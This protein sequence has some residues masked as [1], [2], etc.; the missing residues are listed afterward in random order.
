[1]YVSG[2]VTLSL[3]SV[4][5][6]AQTHSNSRVLQAR[7]A[8]SVLS[9]PNVTTVSSS[10]GLYVQAL[11]GGQVD[12]SG[13]NQ[14]VQGKVQFNSDGPDSLID[15]TSLTSF[16]GITDF[17]SPGFVATNQGTIVSTSLTTVKAAVITLDATAG[18]M[19]TRQI[20]SFTDGG[21]L[22]VSGSSAT[23]AVWP[24]WTR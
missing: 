22:N 18:I 7:G 13:V 4:T 14:E 10:G 2:G 9:L 24:C 23:S 11:A 5:S 1:M 20:T 21:T 19:D 15:L 17:F 16:H 6:Y 8:A 12:L 3:P